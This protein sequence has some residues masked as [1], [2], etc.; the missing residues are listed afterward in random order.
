MHHSYRDITDR[1]AEHPRWWDEHAVPRYCAFSPDETA[2]IYAEE[3]VLLHIIC[4]GCSARFDVC[5]SSDMMMIALRSGDTSHLS[6]DDFRQR[7]RDRSLAS[8]ILADQIHY[9]DPPNYGCCAAGPTMNSVPMYVKEFWLRRPL[10]NWIRIPQLER[11]IDPDWWK[12]K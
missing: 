4:Q 9:G 12:D 6:G 2:N 11:E 3:V 8:A 7:I 10:L 1:L 5:M